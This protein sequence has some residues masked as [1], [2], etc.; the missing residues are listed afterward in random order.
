[1]AKN[2]NSTRHYS[3]IQEKHVAKAL[4]GM[5]VA[6]SGAGK[7]KKGDVVVPGAKLLVECKTSM[8]KKQ[9]FSIKEDWIIKNSIEAFENRLD[10]HCVCFNFGPNEPNYYVINETLMSFLCLKLEEMYNSE[11]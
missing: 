3:D 5:K 8:S 11:K 7:F 9:S 6:N 10:S 4:C 1:M 2:E